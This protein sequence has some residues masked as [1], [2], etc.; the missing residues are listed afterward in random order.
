GDGEPAWRH[1]FYI[2]GSLGV[3]WCVLFW[4]WFRDRPEQKPGVNRGELDLIRGD[5][6][7]PEAAH[8]RVPWGRLLTNLN[9]WTLCLMY[10]C[11]AYGWYFN[12]TYLP[13]YLEER[14]GIVKGEKWSPEFWSFSLMAGAPLLLGSL[15]GVAGGLLTDAFTRRPGNR[16]WGRRLFGVVGHSICAAC[17]FLSVYASNPWVFVLAIALAAFWN[18]LTMGSAWASCLDIGRQYSGIVAG[19]M[20]TVGNLGGAVA[21][22]RTGWVLDHHAGARETGWAITF[23]TFGAVYVIAPL[24]WLHFDSPR[25]V[26]PDEPPAA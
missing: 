13:G 23:F 4:W 22:S 9:L 12:I 25:G 3:L 26:V 8:A 18:D 15:A 10:F 1:T 17:Y 5:E 14:Y 2:F 16:R 24:F 7:P 11:A 6:G 20:N 21:G 19:C